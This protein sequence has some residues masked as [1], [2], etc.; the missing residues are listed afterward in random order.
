MELARQSAW[1]QAWKECLCSLELTQSTTVSLMKVRYCTQPHVYTCLRENETWLCATFTGPVS[2]QI[3]QL[4]DMLTKSIGA[5]IKDKNL[6]AL[7]GRCAAA[8]LLSGQVITSTCLFNL[9]KRV[10]HDLFQHLQRISLKKHSPVMM[11][12]R[13]GR[14]ENLK[15][16]TGRGLS[17]TIAREDQDRD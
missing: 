7:E 17:L 1:G 8:H 16:W 2:S 6:S 15:I 9:T 12:R 11:E 3:L 13:K 10:Q 4:K 14:K 5:Y